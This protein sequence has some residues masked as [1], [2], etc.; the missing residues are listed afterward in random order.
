MRDHSHW[1]VW[2]LYG[3]QVFVE[4]SRILVVKNTNFFPLLL[5]LLPTKRD[6][7]QNQVKLLET[8]RE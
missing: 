1:S 2:S 6:K 5:L 4:N 8:T 3:I 7:K